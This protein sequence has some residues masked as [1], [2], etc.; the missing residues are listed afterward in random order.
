MT[1]LGTADPSCVDRRWRGY[2]TR[3]SVASTRRSGGRGRAARGRQARQ[4]RP[5]GTPAAPISS[6]HGRRGRWMARLRSSAPRR[7]SSAHMSSRA[8]S[9]YRPGGT[10]A[11]GSAMPRGRRACD[12]TCPGPPR[13]SDAAALATRARCECRRLRGCSMASGSRHL[14]PGAPRRV[15]HHSSSHGARSLIV[16]PR[17][18]ERPGRRCDAALLSRHRAG[19]AVTL[20][21][22]RVGPNVSPGNVPMQRRWFSVHVPSTSFASAGFRPPQPFTRLPAICRHF[23]PTGERL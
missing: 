7:S 10:A 18:A 11:R 13:I 22:S 17:R 15:R 19:L 3:R 8:S 14:A 21:I 16:T 20:A 9:S 6:R 2:R 1:I 12:T 5:D 4:S 23:V